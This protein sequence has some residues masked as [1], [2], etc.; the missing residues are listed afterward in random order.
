MTGFEQSFQI[1]QIH[2]YFEKLSIF[3]QCIQWIIWW[4][5]GALEYWTEFHST[6]S[7]CA[8]LHCTDFPL[9]KE[10]HEIA[11]EDGHKLN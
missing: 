4:W 5:C 6:V 2:V 7:R 10:R 3:G 8:K 9:V 11:K 1:S